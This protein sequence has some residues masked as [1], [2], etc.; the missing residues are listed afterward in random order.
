MGFSLG[1][2]VGKILGGGGGSST[3]TA[4]SKNNIDFRPTTN[5]TVE[6]DTDSLIKAIE[7]SSDEATKTNAKLELIKIKQYQEN[8]KKEQLQNSLLLEQLD[9]FKQ[10]IPFSI[11]VF[12]GYQYY[13]KKGR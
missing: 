1:G 5:V 8:T 7:T 13:K 2:F 12:L 3:A 9:S 10:L 11:V 6:F 4:T